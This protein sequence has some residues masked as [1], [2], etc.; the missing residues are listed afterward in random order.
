[1][2]AFNVEN[3]IGKSSIFVTDHVKD[4][5]KNDACDN[6]DPHSWLHAFENISVITWT[7]LCIEAIILLFC[8]FFT[9]F[10]DGWTML[11]HPLTCFK[12]HSSYLLEGVACVK[13]PCA[14]LQH[15]LEIFVFILVIFFLEELTEQDST[16]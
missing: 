11:I 5:S 4:K 8:D 9:N 15:I 16:S 3:Q 6:H 14:C 2:D 7:K 13:N 12:Y 10:F 1:M